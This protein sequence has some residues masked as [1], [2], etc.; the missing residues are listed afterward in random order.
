MGI[1]PPGLILA[2]KVLLPTEV[3]PEPSAK[4]LKEVS[5]SIQA[6]GFK[7]DIQIFE[8]RISEV[9]S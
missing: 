2:Q 7:L 1:P 9:E 6:I 3:A 4:I 8:A 5:C